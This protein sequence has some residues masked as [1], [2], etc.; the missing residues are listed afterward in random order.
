MTV[1]QHGVIDFVAHDPDEDAVLLVMV[2]AREWGDAGERLPDLQEKL[3]TY[4]RYATAGQL[5]VDYPRMAGKPVRIELRAA[6]APGERELEFLR[7]VTARHL[8]PAGISFRW[9]VIGG[10]TPSTR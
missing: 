3:N 7:I 6:S 2:E 8:K 10:S 4:L 1:E 9:R 5:A